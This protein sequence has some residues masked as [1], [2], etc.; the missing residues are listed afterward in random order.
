MDVF[1][2]NISA[3]LPLYFRGI[4]HLACESTQGIQVLP[5][6][7]FL[8]KSLICY[9]FCLKMSLLTTLIT[10][11]IVCMFKNH[12]L[13][14]AQLSGRTFEFSQKK[15]KKIDTLPTKKQPITEVAVAIFFCF[16]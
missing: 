7:I 6:L 5:I 1:A 15:N 16:S 9:C 12:P 2:L 4:N 10:F 14:A 11:N 3:V 8:I 13:H